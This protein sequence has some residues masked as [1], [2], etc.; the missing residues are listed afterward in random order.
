M[1]G[2]MSPTS[3]TNFLVQILIMNLSEK[4]IL[5]NRTEGRGTQRG[6]RGTRRGG[7]I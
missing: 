7:F 5:M 3:L 4:N 2:H 6:G 1:P